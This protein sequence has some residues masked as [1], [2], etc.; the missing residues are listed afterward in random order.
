MLISLFRRRQPIEHPT[1]ELSQ[2][3]KDA[4]V[5]KRVNQC[6]TLFATGRAFEALYNAYY[7]IEPKMIPP[8]IVPAMF[9]LKFPKTPSWF[10]GTEDPEPEFC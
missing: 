1:A 3:A 2:E 10:T 9:K 7:N 5:V 8:D 4:L 6:I